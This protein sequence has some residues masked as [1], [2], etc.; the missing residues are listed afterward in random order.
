MNKREQVQNEA[1]DIAIKNKRCGLGISMGVGKTLIG[2]KY[3]D[4]FQSK[5]M[6]K[7]QVLV[8][9]PKLSIFES[10]KDD[11]KKFNININHVSFTTYLSLNKYNPSDYNLL[12]LDECHSLLYS[13][14]EFLS[15][16]NGFT[17]GLTGTPPRYQDSEKGVMVEKYCP[18]KYKY[19]TDDAVD[20]KILNDYRIIVHRMLLSTSNNLSIEAKGKK[21]Y[22]S[23]E[24]NYAY[25]TQRMWEANTPKQKQI[26][27]VMR[28]RAIMD[29][30]T[31]EIYAKELLND[32]D[33]KCICFAN[34]QD[35]ADRICS[36]SV[37]SNN[38]NGDQ[39]L[40]M[41]KDGD[42]EKLSCVLQLNE[43]VNIPNLRAGI[44]MHA[45]GN[46][47]KSNQRIG[48]LL[49]LNPTETATIHILCYK[50]T[51]DE[52][53]V[54]KALQDLDQSKIKYFDV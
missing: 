12:V 48:R 6:K 52:E 49:R 13:H 41:F 31:K 8:V 10:W 9:A 43:G 38:P 22:T 15:K 28:M 40:Q 24:R 33:E 23:E 30:R 39:N 53:W 25:W 50:N 3:I 51:I 45:Y 47:R 16:F 4:H 19:I 34:T 27:S 11:A 42:I 17:L 36:F 2:L 1:L 5:N 54:I 29:Y 21:F 26:T 44:I 20:D 32:I 37:H 7:L 46:E 35:Q 14:E 18:I